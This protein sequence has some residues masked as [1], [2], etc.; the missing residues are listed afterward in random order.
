MTENS[1]EGTTPEAPEPTTA[2]AAEAP[3][4]PAEN[5]GSGRFAVYDTTLMR[6]VGSVSD[7]R[8]SK[9]EANKLVH[10]RD[11]YSIREV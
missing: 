2:P 8:P 7:K 3:T 10:T 11:A 9:A 1:P 4:L 6:Y 5:S